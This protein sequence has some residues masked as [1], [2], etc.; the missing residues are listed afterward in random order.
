MGQFATRSLVACCVFL[1]FGAT[2]NAQLQAPSSIPLTKQS[3]ALPAGVQLPAM[4]PMPSAE[5][6]PVVVATSPVVRPA[7]TPKVVELP[8]DGHPG[9]KVGSTWYDFQT[10]AAMPNRVSFYRDGSDKYLQV[11]WMAS[12]DGTRDAATRIPGFNTARGSHYNYLDANDPND[13]IVGIEDWQK[14]ETERAGWPSIGQ[15][16]DGS[17]GTASHTPVRYFR[18]AGVGDDFFF[19]FSQVTQ[20][21]ENGLWPRVAV[22]G[23]DNIHLIYHREMPDESSQLVYRRSTDGGTNWEPELFFTGPNGVLPQGQT[24]TLPNSA[25]GDTY[26]IAARGNV[27]AV[28]Y[29]DSPL[30]T[31]VRKSTD[32]GATWDDPTI[33]SLIL[34]IPQTHTFIDSAE[35]TPGQIRL[36]SDTTV[37]PSSHHAVAIDS[38][39]RVHVAT[40]QSLT[41]VITEGSFDPNVGDRRGIIYSVDEDSFFRGT[42][43]YYWPEG[44][45]LIYNVAIAGGDQ[46]DGEGT[47]VSRR[48]YRGASRYPNLGLDENDNVYRVYTSVASGDHMEMQIDTT[49]RFDP[50][51]PDTLVTVNGL[52]GHIYGTWR[53]KNNAAWS[54]PVSLTP[55]GV[56]CLFGTLCD[57]VV[58]NTMYMA[59]SASA[60]PGDR[61]TNVETEASEADIM[62]A[63]LPTSRLGL[64]NSVSEARE[65]DATV[66]V[67]P[68]PA[69]A[70]ARVHITSVTPGEIAV[71]LYTVQGERIMRSASPSADGQWLLEIPTDGLATGAYLLTVEQGGATLTRT[72]NV[73]H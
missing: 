69:D 31:L 48:A 32:Y 40:G 67:M 50:L 30:R 41:Y 16:S 70:A 21:A 66:A 53:Y 11:L 42:G 15:F 43:I 24:G 39:G 22:D 45:T 62:V 58:E 26:A 54:T 14:M 29:S 65:L 1:T 10:N 59:Y 18:N 12:K 36:W 9:V 37:A 38:E 68:N 13:L 57:D 4:L 17:I 64:P 28:V 6:E 52:Y 20:E 71:S 47:I 73:L 61:V 27:V 23:Q 51:E 46:W 56:N 7:S 49:P 33:N 19:E 2:T 55:N 35:T 8:Q 72:L 63:A 44:D 60:I 5:N 25:G 34:L 3:A